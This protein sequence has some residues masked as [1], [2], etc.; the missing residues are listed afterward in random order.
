MLL[1]TW[2]YNFDASCKAKVYQGLISS[3]NWR[4]MP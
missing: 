1:V 4:V 3:Y 2:P